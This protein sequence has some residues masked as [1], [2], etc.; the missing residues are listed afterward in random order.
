MAADALALGNVP[1]R[2][3]DAYRVVADAQKAAFAM[4]RPGVMTTAADRAARSSW[5][6]K[7][8]SARTS[9]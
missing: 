9:T 5:S 7:P 2:L 4:L 6:C 1:S 3:K 8:A